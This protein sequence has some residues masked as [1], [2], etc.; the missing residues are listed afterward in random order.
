M[1]IYD[2]LFNETCK[3]KER[4]IVLEVKVHE[5]DELNVTLKETKKELSDNIVSL[6]SE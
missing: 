2:G 6:E 3:I 5:L 1:K 4:N